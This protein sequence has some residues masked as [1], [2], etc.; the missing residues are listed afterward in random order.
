MTYRFITILLTLTV[1]FCS[2][3]S[4][5]SLTN[6]SIIIETLLNAQPYQNVDQLAQTLLTKHKNNMSQ[7]EAHFITYAQKKINSIRMNVWNSV[8]YLTAFESDPVLRQVM[9][10]IITIEKREAKKGN[11]TFVHGQPWIL[12]FYEELYTF[13]WKTITKTNVQDFL[14]LRFKNL[15]FSDAQQ[16]IDKLN[17][18]KKK[19][20]YYLKHGTH[21]YYAG[22][23]SGKTNQNYIMFLNYALFNNQF[24][25]SSARYMAKGDSENGI[26]KWLKISNIFDYLGL[27][28]YY[29]PFKNELKQLKK[30]HKRLTQQK[31]Q[32]YGHPLVIS[33]SPSMLNKVVYISWTGNKQ[34]FNLANGKKT[35]NVKQVLDLL[36]TNPYALADQYSGY[37]NSDRNE[38][39]MILSLD[40]AL[41][42]NNGI[43]VYS[44]PPVEQQKWS[45][46][47]KKRDAL[48]TRIK[49][50]IIAQAFGSTNTQ[51]WQSVVKILY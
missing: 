9:H 6:P 34:Q 25:S 44:I 1:Q 27:E 15:Y 32:Q 16:F 33:I 29:L 41:K 28:N 23:T 24:G 42:P 7:T 22:G 18:H 31:N 4:T 36:R 21:G 35:T 51:Y 3:F 37:M 46:F 11:Y 50:S 45:S 12:H 5:Q 8:N 49:Q 43:Y 17:K 47:C 48:F 26:S 40:G 39:S 13:L 38:F 20:F 30:N 10:D 14:F 19:H 2:T